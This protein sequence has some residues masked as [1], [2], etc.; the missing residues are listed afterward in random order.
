[1]FFW[2]AYTIANSLEH[3]KHAYIP[4]LPLFIAIVNIQLGKLKSFQTD[5]TRVAIGLLLYFIADN[6][7]SLFVLIYFCAMLVNL[8]A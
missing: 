2:S 4:S 5:R 1:M 7:G 3:L 8:L 6:G